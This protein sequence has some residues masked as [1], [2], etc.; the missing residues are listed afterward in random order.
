MIELAFVLAII[1]SFWLGFYLRTIS[2]KVKQFNQSVQA[3]K[4]PEASKAIIIDGND[5][6]QMAMIEE[7]AR[8]AKLNTPVSRQ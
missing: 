2:D 4:D 7:K 6:I 1:A 5:V 8:L 3:K